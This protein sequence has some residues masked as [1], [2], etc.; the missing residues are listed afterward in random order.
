L[1]AAPGGLDPAGPPAGDPQLRSTLAVTGYQVKATDGPVGTISG[2]VIHGTDWTI[3]ELLIQGNHAWDD[4][5][6]SV[7][8]ADVD[9]ISYP[10]ATVFLTRS[11]AAMRSA[12]APAPV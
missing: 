12:V 9:R 6:F 11:K 7:S 10:E 4:E 5:E 3:R 8:P 2:F 1:D